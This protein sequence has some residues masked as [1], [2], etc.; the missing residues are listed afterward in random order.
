MRKPLRFKRKKKRVSFLRQKFFWYGTGLLFFLT[1]LFYTVVFSPWLEIQDVEV[2]GAKEIPKEHIVAAVERSFWQEFWGIP[3]NSILLV[4]TAELKE[5]LVN[6]FPLIFEVSLKRSLPKTLVVKIQERVQVATWCL[7]TKEGK[8]TPCFALD[9][10]GIPFKEVK[11][12]DEYVVFHSKGNPNLGKELVDPHLL[13]I[14]LGFKKTFETAGESVQFSTTAFEIGEDG[15]VKAKSKEG[16]EILLDLEKSIEWQQTKLK[17]VLQQ[18]IPQEQRG[19]LEY[20]D[21][22]FGDQAYLKYRD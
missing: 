12:M 8:D 9:S 21:L 22:R 18:K 6:S 10:N 1:F 17:L 20:I 4:R 7:P 16:W 3:Q 2:Q 15:Q 13:S 5:H 19:K 14:L 11:D